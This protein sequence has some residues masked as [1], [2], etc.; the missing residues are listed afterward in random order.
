MTEMVP[1]PASTVTLLD[2]YTR[3]VEMN[4][5]LAV[6]HEQLRAIP[7]HENRLRALETAMP[8]GASSRM[9]VLEQFRWKIAGVAGLIS[10]LCGGVVASIVVWALNRH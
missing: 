4:A 6:I 5:Q 9:A 2:I 7:D 1:G 3:Q 8:D 10:V